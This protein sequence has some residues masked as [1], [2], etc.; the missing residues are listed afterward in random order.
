MHQPS[1]ASQHQSSVT[2]NTT[3]CETSQR[4]Y[5]HSGDARAHK[6]PTVL[7]KKYDSTM[8]FDV[9]YNSEEAPHNWATVRGV[10]GGGEYC[11]LVVLMRT[12]RCGTRLSNRRDCHWECS[13]VG[14]VQ[15]GSASTAGW[16][17]CERAGQRMFP[18]R[19]PHAHAHALTESLP[20]LARK[21]PA[22]S[23][24]RRAQNGITR[25]P[26]LT[27]SRHGENWRIE[28]RLMCMVQPAEPHVSH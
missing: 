21:S 27:C 2:P 1:I 7:H 22:G 8:Y 5:V 26:S 20:D 23:R 24:S 25:A 9:Q 13:N 3:S 11:T 16:A 19:S 10:E 18:R 6:P 17:D 4:K 28:A 12:A 15:R 14:G